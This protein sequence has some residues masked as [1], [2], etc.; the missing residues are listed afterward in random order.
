MRKF[1]SKISQWKLSLSTHC[2]PALILAI[3]M[4]NSINLTILRW[5]PLT[6]HIS[7]MVFVFRLKQEMKFSSY[8]EGGTSPYFIF[9]KMNFH[10]V[11]QK[12]VQ[13]LRYCSHHQSYFSSKSS[14]SNQLT[15]TYSPVPLIGLF[16]SLS[17]Q[18]YGQPDF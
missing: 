9:P 6:V 8:L 2:L 16:L 11:R 12:F 3:A 15:R 1:R 13:K 14:T 17:V 4:T 5:Q 10:L 18:G 7:Y